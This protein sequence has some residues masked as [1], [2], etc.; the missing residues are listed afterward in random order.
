MA[1]KLR[2]LGQRKRQHNF[3]RLLFC[4]LVLTLT[5]GLELSEAFFQ[6]QP[7]QKTKSKVE[8]A[9]SADEDAAKTSSVRK[10]RRTDPEAN[11]GK[12]R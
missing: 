12:K 2:I 10:S 9:K 3:K 8:S 4:S 1:Q 6:F 11:R 7:A 5:F